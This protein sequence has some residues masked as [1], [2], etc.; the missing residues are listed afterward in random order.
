LVHEWSAG[1][2]SGVAQDFHGG[3]L[4]EATLVQSRA[5]LGAFVV[6]GAQLASYRDR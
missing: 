1:E 2:D 3:Q 4:G 6:T 5:R